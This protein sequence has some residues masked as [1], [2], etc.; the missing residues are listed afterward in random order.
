MG[1]AGLLC[2]P[3]PSTL[4][5]LWSQMLQKLGE[6]EPRVEKPLAE[7]DHLGHTDWVRHGFLWPG[8]EST[9]HPEGFVLGGP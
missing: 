5:S 6:D 4:T 3:L 1:L 2:V 8:T 9:V 7:L